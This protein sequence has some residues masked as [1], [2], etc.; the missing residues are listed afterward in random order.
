MTALMVP[1][2]PT[3]STGNVTLPAWFTGRKESGE[4]SPHSSINSFTA[5]GLNIKPSHS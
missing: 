3:P 2:T 4:P 1:L 5:P